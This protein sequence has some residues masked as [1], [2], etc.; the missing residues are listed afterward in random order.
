MYICICIV[1]PRPSSRDSCMYSVCILTI[2]MHTPTHINVHTYIS[3][4]TCIQDVIFTLPYLF[5]ASRV[6]IV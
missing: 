5:L 2:C 6:L 4:Y 1:D 3:V